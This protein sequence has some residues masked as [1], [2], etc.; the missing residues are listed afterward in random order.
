MLNYGLTHAKNADVNGSESDA[1]LFVELPDTDLNVGDVLNAPIILGTEA[2]PAVDVYGIAFTINFDGDL[3]EEESIEI[4]FSDCWLG[5][6]GENLITLAQVFGDSG[7]IEVAISR[8]DLESQTGYGTIGTLTGII[9]NI[10]GKKNAKD[11][12]V[13]ISNVRAI[14][15]DETEIPVFTTA[16]SVVIYQYSTRSIGAIYPTISQPN[17]HICYPTSS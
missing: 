16:D 9:D 2:I 4:D 17:K 15:A 5:T 11:L 7:T 12:V 8:T 14:S 1:P 6:E 3:L 10:A 13:S